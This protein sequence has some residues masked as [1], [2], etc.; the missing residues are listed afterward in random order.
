MRELEQLFARLAKSA[1]RGKF[2][3]QAKDLQYLQAK[4]LPTICEHARDF[5]G[6]RLA[7]ALIP[8]DGK[9]TPYRGHPVFVAQHSTACCCRGC[10]QKWHGIAQ[11][12]MLSAEE[13]NY[14][15]EVLM[16]WL[17]RE[18]QRVSDA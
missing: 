15:V 2:R 8:N 16:H 4:G 3:L 1:F 7:P 5:V 14:V 6:K 11:G 18:I 12:R 10:L 9:Q 13:Q 17:R